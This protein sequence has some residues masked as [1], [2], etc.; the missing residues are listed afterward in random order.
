MQHQANTFQLGIIKAF[1]RKTIPYL[2]LTLRSLT[3]RLFTSTHPDVPSTLLSPKKLISMT[4]FL[5]GFFSH[6]LTIHRT[7]GKGRKQSLFLFTVSARSRTF[8]H[9]FKTL[10]VTW[11]PRIFNHAAFN[12]QTANRWDLPPSG[13]TILIDDEMSISVSALDD[14]ILGLYYSNFTKEAGGF[15]LAFRPS[16]LNYSNVFQ[17]IYSNVLNLV[18][19]K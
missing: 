8:R 1:I 11:L 6:T 2:I 12:Y 14:F 15:K 13:I 4:F 16:S 7:V 3:G 5:S 18:W 9:F 19:H 10:H 17:C